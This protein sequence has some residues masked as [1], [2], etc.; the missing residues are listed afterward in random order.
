MKY[1]LIGLLVVIITAAGCSRYAVPQAGSSHPAH[2]QAPAPADMEQ[3]QMLRVDRDNLPQTP[4]EMIHMNSM[5][6]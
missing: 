6:H 3:A 5:Q 4:P 2:P 1:P